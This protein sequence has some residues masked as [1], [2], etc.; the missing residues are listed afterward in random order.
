M[1]VKEI[2]KSIL[3]TDL[4]FIAH[5]VNCQGRMGS[6]VAKVLYEKYPQIKEQYLEYYDSGIHL[7]L[8][9]TEDFL[10][11]VQPVKVNDGKIIYN[12]FTQDNY[13][14][15][16]KLYVDYNSIESC[17]KLLVEM[18]PEVN[19]IAIP[20]I[21]AGLA[22]GNWEIIKK[23]IN[24]TTGNKLDVYVYKLKENK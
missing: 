14:Y 20:K 6:G 21:G 8:N 10:G 5:G 7:A 11:S 2:T 12:L 1:I 3:D 15:D 4:N 24:E 23:I 13:G 18:C 16:G 22:G 19:A 9:G 17:F